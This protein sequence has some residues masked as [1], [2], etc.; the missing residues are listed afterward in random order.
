MTIS[1]LFAKYQVCYV[2][3]HVTT[4]DSKYAKVILA[5]IYIYIYIDMENKEEREK[6]R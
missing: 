1:R 5:K 3:L 2:N 6:C 4:K